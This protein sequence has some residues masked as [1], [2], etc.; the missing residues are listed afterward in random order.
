MALRTTVN[1]EYTDGR[2]DTY[3]D[4]N[5]EYQNGVF[6]LSR[7]TTDMATEGGKFETISFPLHLLSKV[8]STTERL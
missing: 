8:T 7:E 5:A 1:I 4:W 2:N 6:I 3:V